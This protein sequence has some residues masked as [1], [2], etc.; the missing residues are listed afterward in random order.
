[1]RRDFSLPIPSR[2]CRRRR[3]VIATRGRWHASS[4]RGPS[5]PL[6]VSAA[7]RRSRGRSRH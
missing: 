6:P 5:A 1:V 2:L 4:T 7:R 3:Q